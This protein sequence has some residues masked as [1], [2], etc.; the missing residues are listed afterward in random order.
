MIEVWGK[1]DKNAK[2]CPEVM[3]YIDGKK[4]N[5]TIRKPGNYTLKIKQTED[6]YLEQ[7]ISV[8]LKKKHQL[9]TYTHMQQAGCGLQKYVL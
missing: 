2:I 7:Q 9:L 8:E 6:S 4:L 1:F 3:V 5:Y